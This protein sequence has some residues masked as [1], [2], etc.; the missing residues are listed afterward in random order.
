MPLLMRYW[1][2]VPGTARHQNVVGDP[3]TYRCIPSIRR[4]W[5]DSRRSA[6]RRAVSEHDSL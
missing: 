2:G 3:Q 6:D 5:T 4:W 1:C